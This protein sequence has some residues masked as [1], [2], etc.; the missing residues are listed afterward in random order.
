MI[1]LLLEKIDLRVTPLHE[2]GEAEIVYA[3]QWKRQ[4][5]ALWSLVQGMA[6]ASPKSACF[7]VEV[8]MQVS[9]EL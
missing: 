6:T 4:D 5:A 7:C 2:N 9:Y 8:H 1:N 3:E